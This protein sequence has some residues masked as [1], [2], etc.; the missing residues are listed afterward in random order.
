MCNNSRHD[1]N[2]IYNHPRVNKGSYPHGCL[3]N[4]D[5]YQQGSL[6]YKD[7]YP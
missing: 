2:G 6:D 1:G 5:S 3:D 4:K 7:I